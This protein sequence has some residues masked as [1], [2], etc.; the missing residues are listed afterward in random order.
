MRI[1]NESV[2]P[3]S[4]QEFV[5]REES[6]DCQSGQDEDFFAALVCCRQYSAFQI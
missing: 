4:L 6:K 2:G 3:A 5:D 1:L